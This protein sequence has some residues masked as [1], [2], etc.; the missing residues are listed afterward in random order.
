M[1]WDFGVARFWGNSCFLFKFCVVLCRAGWY[2]MRERRTFVFHIL[3]PTQSWRF[4]VGTQNVALSLCCVVFCMLAFGVYCLVS[5]I[6]ICIVFCGVL[7]C[8]NC[9]L[10]ACQVLWFQLNPCLLSTLRIAERF[11]L[12]FWATTLNRDPIPCLLTLNEMLCL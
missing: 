4:C 7:F 6:L 11:S 3:C 12:F 9:D 10:W 8:L 5:C 1:S 2:G